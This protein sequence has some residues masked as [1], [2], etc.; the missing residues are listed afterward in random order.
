MPRRIRYVT[1]E[2]PRG[3]TSTPLISGELSGTN[4]PQ[5]LD[6]STPKTSS[7][8]PP[9]ERTTLSRST[10][11]LGFAGTSLILPATISTRIITTVSPKKTMRH[12]PYVVTRPPIRGPAAAASPVTAPR[13]EKAATR[14][15]P[16]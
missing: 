5:V 4:Q 7:A 6:W 10:L 8:M 12:D 15:L 9:A 16:V 1:S 3:A 2:T 14:A 13:I 11:S